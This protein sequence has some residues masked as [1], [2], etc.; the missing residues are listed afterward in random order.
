MSNPV[1]LTEETA[2]RFADATRYV[3]RLPDFIGS[4]GENRAQIIQGQES[5]ILYGL[6]SAAWSSGA[7]I[8]LTP[9]DLAG[10]ATGADDVD[11]NLIADGSSYS[12]VNYDAGGGSAATGC[13]IPTT[14]IVAYT[15]IGDGTAYV[16]GEPAVVF[17]SPTDAFF[18]SISGKLQMR[19]R[20]QIGGAL[21]TL[22]NWLDMVQSTPSKE[23]A[24]TAP[25][26]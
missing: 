11:V 26:S 25:G 13:T 10:T 17:P 2:G 7:T 5:P 8:T 19:V 9:C 14:A 16:V 24:C 1:L 12:I 23:T 18:R 4:T 6:P 20:F 15:V 21:S 22:S 3:E